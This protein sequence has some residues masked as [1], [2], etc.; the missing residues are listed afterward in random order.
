[1]R[2]EKKSLRAGVISKHRKMNTG[3]KPLE[4]HIQ[5]NI[6][7]ESYTTRSTNGCQR[8][9]TTRGLL[10]VTAIFNAPGEL[11]ATHKYINTTSLFITQPTD[12]ILYSCTAE[13]SLLFRW[14]ALISLMI[15][16]RRSCDLSQALKR[17]QEKGKEQL[18]IA[19]MGPAMKTRLQRT[20]QPIDKRHRLLRDEKAPM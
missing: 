10:I 11:G 14:S 12:D 15:N 19:L 17:T 8:T 4:V 18:R 1:M 6:M 5:N 9:R 2:E 16:K 20:L 7:R 3:Q 13:A